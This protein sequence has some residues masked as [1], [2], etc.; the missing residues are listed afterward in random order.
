[1]TWNRAG[2]LLA[3]VSDDS[4]LRLWGYNYKGSGELTAVSCTPT[5]HALNM[6]GT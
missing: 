4:T 1:M 3:S 6:F 2:T 5:R